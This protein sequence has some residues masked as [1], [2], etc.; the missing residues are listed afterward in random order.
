[1]SAQND[2]QAGVDAFIRGISELAWRTYIEQSDVRLL[3]NEIAER[4]ANVRLRDVVHPIR[5]L[6]QMAGAPPLQLGTAGFRLDLLD[7]YNPARHYSALLFVGFYVPRFL[8]TLI[9]FGWEIAGFVRY[10]GQWSSPDIR[11]GL[12][13]IRHGRL[14]RRYGGVV[15]PALI[16]AQVA[17]KVDDWESPIDINNPAD[18]DQPTAAIQQVN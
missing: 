18:T 4:Y 14:V 13:G 2:S 16:A 17:E 7:D 6:R 3:V 1:L 12:L 8:A 9:L 10:R 5:F 15:L 11:S